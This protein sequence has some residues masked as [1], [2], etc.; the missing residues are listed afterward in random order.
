MAFLFY[1]LLQNKD[2]TLEQ[3]KDLLMEQIEIVKKGNFDE[4]LIKAI[5][6][7]EKLAPAS[8]HRK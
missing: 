6:S 1:L 2:E 8:R 7:N 4:S 5:V 3:A